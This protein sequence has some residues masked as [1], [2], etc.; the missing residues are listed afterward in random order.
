MG[1]GAINAE[2]DS[3]SDR[4]PGWI[5]CVTIKTHLKQNARGDVKWENTK[6]T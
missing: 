3:I 2:E 4:G 1:R 6:V 5:L